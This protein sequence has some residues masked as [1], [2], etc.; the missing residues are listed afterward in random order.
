VLIQQKLGR[1]QHQRSKTQ[2][3]QHSL[4]QHEITNCR[5]QA[6]TLTTINECNGEFVKR[7]G[8]GFA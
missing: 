1:N 8:T 2:S 5:E 7:D 4:F 6:I 3:N